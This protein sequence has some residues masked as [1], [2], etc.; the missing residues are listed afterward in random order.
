MDV[1]HNLAQ[2]LAV[3]LAPVNLFACFVGVFV[4]TL[5][6][7]LPGIGP[8]ATMSLLLPIT[9]AM[10]PT[11]SIIMLA[12]IY[13][14]AMYGG[15]TTSILAN[16]PGEST[17]VV[18]CLDGYQ[19]ARQGRAGAALGI[20]A[21]G[22]FIAGTLSVV[23]ITLLAPPLARAALAFGPP[24][25]FAVLLLAFTLV[26][27]LAGGSPLKTA[28]MALLGM[29]LGTVGIDP[30]SGIARFTFGTVTLNDGVG[31]LPMIMGLFGVSEVL[32]NVERQVQHEIYG[33]RIT[34]LLP[35]RQ[36]WRDSAQPIARGSVLGFFLG[37]LPGMGAIIPTFI[38]YALE[39][40]VSRTPERF[41]HGAIEGVAGPEAANNA[42]AGGALIPLLT[43]GVAPNVPMAIL[44]GA[45]LIHGIQPGPL[46]LTEHPALFWGVVASMY[47]GNVMLLV[48]N[49]PLIG[50]WVQLLRVP[51]GLLFPLILL[52]CVIGV[53]SEAANPHD[54]VV[55][56]VFGVLGYFMKKL[57]FEAAPMVLAF[58][59]GRMAEEALRQSLLLSRGS[60]AILVNRPLASTI[61][62]LAVAAAIL[63]VAL[64][65]VR[66]RLRALP[67]E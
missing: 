13:Y 24:E 10:S 58:V 3:S 15:S 36:D 29:L 12:G 46:M 50:L 5:I 20:A 1:V 18:T 40:R 54:L 8:V 14:G 47:V 38:S 25:I 16:I 66:A 60:L 55:L 4:G 43:L 63:P 28:A 37:I 30:I 39:R 48:L 64:P 41:G 53:W 51:Y 57:G 23:G 21:F 32:L 61:L 26:T 2:G 17:S 49:L 56:F 42:A 6:G 22:S 9:Y 52:F 65:W 7:V 67:E 33:A 27:Q 34:R 45:F 19:M 59:L 35:S 31:L 62:G 11:A 44:L